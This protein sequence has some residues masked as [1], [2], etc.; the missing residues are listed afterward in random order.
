M[1]AKR[2]LVIAIVATWCPTCVTSKPEI[3]RAQGLLAA[4]GTQVYIIDA[5]QQAAVV[6]KYNVTEFPTVLHRSVDGT[7]R[8][9][10]WPTTGILTAEDIVAFASSPAI[11]TRVAGSL[12]PD[13]TNGGPCTTSDTSVDPT[14]WGPGT[15]RLIHSVAQAY[16]ATPTPQDKL[17]AAK[18]YFSLAS[19]LPCATCRNDFERI[20][21]SPTSPLRLTKAH[22]ASKDAL[23]AWTVAVHDAVN[24]K[25]GKK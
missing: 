22:L 25:L 17:K 3:Q 9:M 1:T 21:K 2:P 19:V 24:Q 11:N 6:S 23:Y 7:V 8:T 18:F 15:W 5:D 10:P 4:R 13:C 12:P 16:P 20:M 14:F